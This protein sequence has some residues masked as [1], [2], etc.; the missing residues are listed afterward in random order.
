MIKLTRVS[1]SIDFQEDVDLWVNPLLISTLDEDEF[2]T[3]ILIPPYQK[4]IKVRETLKKVLQLIHA[5]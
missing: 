5:P 1:F 4:P 2:G 3:W